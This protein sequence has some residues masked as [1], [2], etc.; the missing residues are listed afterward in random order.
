MDQT[1]VSGNK[2]SSVVL[3]QYHWIVFIE[4]FESIPNSIFQY[5]KTKFDGAN[6]LK[7]IKQSLNM[8]LKVFNKYLIRDRP[9]SSNLMEFL[10]CLWHGQKKISLRTLCLKKTCFRRNKIIRENKFPL[11][12]EA[13][14]LFWLRKKPHPPPLG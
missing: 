14:T 10:F 6:N 13:K 9:L 8:L 4:I 1:I 3:H 2:H 12:G 7:L 5:S 11:S